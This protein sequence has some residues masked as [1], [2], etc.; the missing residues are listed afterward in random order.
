MRKVAKPDTDMP[1]GFVYDVANGLKALMVEKWD[2][3]YL[4]EPTKIP[5]DAPWQLGD[6]TIPD[7]KALEEAL[8]PAR[9]MLFPAAPSVDD[10]QLDDKA[11]PTTP[12]N[13]SERVTRD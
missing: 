5:E 6:L 13:A 12:A 1:F 10:A 9:E 4:Q 11:S 2:V 3:P 7:D 8:K